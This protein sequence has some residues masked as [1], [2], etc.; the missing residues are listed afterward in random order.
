MRTA[1]MKQ[2]KN[3]PCS[4]EGNL[5]NCVLVLRASGLMQWGRASTSPLAQHFIARLSHETS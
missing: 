2:R 1:E 4:C 5:C 3:D